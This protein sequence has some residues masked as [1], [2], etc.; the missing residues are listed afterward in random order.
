MSYKDF[1]FELG[2]EEIPAGYIAAA[3]NKLQDQFE[4]RLKEAKLSY[5]QI[6]QYS[7]PRRFAIKIEELQTKQENEVIE[8]IGPAKMAAYDAEGN[9][10]RAALGFLRGAGAEPEDLFIKETSKGEKIV[11]KKQVDGKPTEEILPLII[12]EAISSLNFPKSMRWGDTATAFARPIRWLLVIFGNDLVPVEY[13][14]IK[15]SRISYGNRFQKLDNPVEISSINIYEEKLESVYV[16]PDRGLRKQKIEEQINY[17]FKG[18]KKEIIPDAGLLEIVTD[19]VEYPTAVIADFAENYLHLPQKVI[20]STLSQ[21][22]KY[23]AVRDTKGH[24]TNQF[25]FISNGDQNY[26]D[27]IKLGNEKVITARLEDAAFFFKEDTDLALENYVPKLAEVT[28]QQQLGSLLEKTERIES[29]VQFISKNLDLANQKEASASRAARLC[30]A[31]LVTLMLGEK[32]FTK[33]QGYMGKIYAEKSGEKPDVCQAIYDH[34]LPRGERDELPS[35]EVGAVVAIADKLDTICGIIG[36]DMIPTGSKDPF[37][38]RRAANGIVQIIAKFGFEFNLFDLVDHAYKRLE[39]KLPK[40]ENNKKVV[41]DFFRQRVNW[42]LKQIKIEYDI[43]DSVMHIDPT[44]IPDLIHRAQAL[45][46][47]KKQTDF[48]RL[49]LGFKRVANI[50][51][52]FKEDSTVKTELLQEEMEQVLFTKSLELKIKIEQL[53]PVKKYDII[54]KHLVEFG[55]IINKFFD[56]VL[57]NVDDKIIKRNRYSL[58]SGIRT[59]FLQVADLSRLVVE[60]EEI[61]KK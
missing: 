36:V 7:T 35:S 31:D 38:L 50:I 33:L 59:L 47:F 26:S 25:I 55:Y 16:I 15:S 24:I 19:L 1:L 17:L 8:R 53:L 45:K 39:A 58:L 44:N 9:L 22:Q 32:E 48:V 29:I 2:A 54:L 21:H 42:L 56:D 18:Q 14:G 27:L 46:E 12:L 20:T 52:D 3:I 6:K 41:Y 30:K 5:K 37:A 28:F 40:P 60:G 43:I 11:I 10:S 34:Y 61:K 23:F 57:V 13:N 51:A 4:S 49:V